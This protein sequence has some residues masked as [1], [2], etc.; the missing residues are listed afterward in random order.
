M[1]WGM[2]A[3]GVY[4]ITEERAT[5]QNVYYMEQTASAFAG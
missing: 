1:C 2:N 3:A 5:T 4:E